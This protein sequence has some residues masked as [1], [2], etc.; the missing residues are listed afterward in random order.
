MFPIKALRLMSASDD[1]LSIFFCGIPPMHLV[2]YTPRFKRRFPRAPALGLADKRTRSLSD[3]RPGRHQ[4][5]S[6]HIELELPPVHLREEAYSPLRFTMLKRW[7]T[8]CSVLPRNLR[9][10]HFQGLPSFLHAS[11]STGSHGIFILMLEPCFFF[12]SNT[13]HRRC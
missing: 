1:N 10:I 2:P 5:T 13:R 9:K 8:A 6:R 3:I 11:S 12:Y 4:G 7:R